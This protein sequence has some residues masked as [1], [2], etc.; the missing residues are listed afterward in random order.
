MNGDNNASVNDTWYM[1]TDDSDV[2]YTWYM[3]IYDI[4]MQL[5]QSQF[6]QFVQDLT[7]NRSSHDSQ[8]V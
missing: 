3:C 8:C 2:G 7:T 4:D 5:G 6:G 1:A